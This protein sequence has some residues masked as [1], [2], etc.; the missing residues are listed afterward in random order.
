MNAEHKR[1]ISE[2]KKG[3]DCRSSEHM[4]KMYDGLRNRSSESIELSSLRRQLTQ[5]RK[6]L[7]TNPNILSRIEEMEC[8]IAEVEEML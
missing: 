8:K 2:A 1:K 4:Q 7:P 5:M 3:K 6:Q